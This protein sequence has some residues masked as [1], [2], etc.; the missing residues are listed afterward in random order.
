MARIVRLITKQLAT[1]IE[2]STFH[3]KQASNRRLILAMLKIAGERT[4]DLIL[5]GEY[6]NLHHR[7][8][9][10]NQREY[11][12]EAIPGAFTSVVARY[13]RKYKMNVALPLF[14]RYRGI[15]SS[16]VVL[17]NR[18]GRIVG[19]YQKTHPTMPEQSIGIQAGEELP[20]YELTSAKWE[21]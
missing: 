10:S 18:E 21:S 4:S 20:V 11:V 14:G 7:T 13:A 9:S 3:E 6:A 2:K 16:Y 19:C 17:F 1:V 8:W 5:F 15:L 12:P